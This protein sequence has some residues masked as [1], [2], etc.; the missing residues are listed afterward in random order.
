GYNAW[1]AELGLADPAGVGSGCRSLVVFDAKAGDPLEMK[2]LAQQEL[3]RRG[4]LWGG[5][6]NVSFSHAD[7]DVEHTLGAWR[8]TLAVLRD[9]VAARDV[10]GRLRGE[11]VGAVLR[12]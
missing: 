9:A 8:E 2:S 5:F 11:P 4:V 12:R 7:A 1:A 6:H 3:I 10:R